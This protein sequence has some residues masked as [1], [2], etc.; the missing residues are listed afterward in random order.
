MSLHNKAQHELDCQICSN[1][2]LIYICTHE[3]QRVVDA[4]REVCTSRADS[5]NWNLVSW[6]LGSQLSVIA[7]DIQ[8]PAGGVPDQLS[9]LQWFEELNS[10][11]TYTILVLK[12]F[13]KLMGS[14][15]HPGQ[16]EYKVIR[17]MRN[18]VQS[19][20]GEYKCIIIMASSLFV[21]KELERTCTVIDWPLPEE[22]DIKLKV[23]SLLKA[24][25]SSPAI[26]S[27]FKTTYN[28]ESLQ[29]SIQAF[30]GLTLEQIQLLSTYLML[31]TDEMNAVSISN[32]KRDAIRKSTVLEWINTD[33]TMD[34]IGGMGGIKEWLHRRKAAFSDEARQ[35][36][37]PYPRGVLLVG[38]QGCGKSSIAKAI[39]STFKQPLL[40]WDFGRLYNSLL[41]STEESVR[42]A[43]KTAESIAPCVLWVDELEKGISGASGG[44]SDG[45]TSSRVFAT[46]LTWMQEKTAPVFLV[47][48]A[49]D[50][51]QIPPEMLR[52][53][54]FDEIF[55]VDLPDDKE[56]E[57]ILR[58]HLKR[59]G[60]A[61]ENLDVAQLIEAT[62]GFTGAEI[63]AVIIEAMHDAFLENQRP[64]H[65]QDLILS[66]E[67]T[68]PL[69]RTMAERIDS[70]R[71]WAQNRARAANSTRGRQHYGTIS[72]VKHITSVEDDEL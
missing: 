43:I 38:I 5:K 16:A 70:L 36:G 4:I 13:H 1:R 20:I 51:S 30:K 26:A 59:T 10:T 9:V 46:F 3:E 58:I 44:H 56:R 68:V 48:T 37:L 42:N 52:K 11:D 17:L 8:L 29:E 31:T 14:D 69:S 49:N 19:M 66:I 71:T 55:F 32:H 23:T 54:R 62:Q 2:P 41:G 61:L 53:G 33:E 6:D 63:E 35:Y 72:N 28:H 50:V 22:D 45:G 21:P 18:M 57:D 64:I 25:E 40:R 65:T 67:E 39:A 24:A 7:G 47:A 60:V 34:T 15:G 12:D 27:R